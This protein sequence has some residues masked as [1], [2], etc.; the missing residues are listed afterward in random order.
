MKAYSVDGN[1][2][3]APL[4]E[5]RTQFLFSGDLVDDS[6]RQSPHLSPKENVDLFLDIMDKSVDSK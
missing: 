1:L 6:I 5:L 4:E 3:S 2:A